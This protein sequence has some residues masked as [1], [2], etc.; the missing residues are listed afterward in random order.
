M[1][2]QD[3]NQ[4]FYLYNNIVDCTFSSIYQHTIWAKSDHLLKRCSSIMEPSCL[5]RV[6]VFFFV[7]THQAIPVSVS[8]PT[9]TRATTTT[10][11]VL[12]IDD[13]SVVWWKITTLHHSRHGNT[14]QSMSCCRYNEVICQ[15]LRLNPTSFVSHTRE[16]MV[17]QNQLKTNSFIG[18]V[19]WPAGHYSW[20]KSTKVIQDGN[21]FSNISSQMSLMI[22]AGYSS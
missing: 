3:A 17:D 22:Y 1:P 18:E 4:L 11:N 9:R 10:A 13:N 6:R 16:C 15:L 7:P 2:S 19:V 20:M 14:F 5:F 8:P 12:L 21:K